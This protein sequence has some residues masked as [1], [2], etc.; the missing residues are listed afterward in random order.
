MLKFFTVAYWPNTNLINNVLNAKLYKVDIFV[1]NNGM[2]QYIYDLLI[3]HCI[4]ILGDGSNVGL[5]AAFHDFENKF[6]NSDDFY[7][8]LDQDT[9]LDSYC[10]A[11]I[12]AKYVELFSDSK[13][14]M[15]YIG[16]NLPKSSIVVSSGSIFSG[17]VQQDIGGHDKSLFVEGLDYEFCYRLI[18]RCYKVKLFSLS[19]YDHISDQDGKL[20]DLLLCRF[21]ARVYGRERLSD[22]NKSHFKLIKK[23][24]NSFDV[25]YFYYFIRSLIA[26]NVRELISRLFFRS[27]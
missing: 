18:K 13:T 14:G 4:N 26:F 19:G 5:G 25:Y 7:I 3:S 8:Y 27:I 1:F 15:L 21:Y 2:D 12:L 22:F 23:A 17:R 6:I 16:A 10:W 20:V 9:I 24:L 11:Q